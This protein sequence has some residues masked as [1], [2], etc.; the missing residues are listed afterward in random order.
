MVWPGLLGRGTALKKHQHFWN[1]EES[2]SKVFYFSYK[3]IILT[4]CST[5]IWIK[6][7]FVGDCKR[8]I[9]EAGYKIRVATEQRRLP[10]KKQ[11]PDKTINT[12]NI[13]VETR[14][15]PF[16]A[17][18]TERKWAKAGWGLRNR[19]TGEH[20]AIGCCLALAREQCSVLASAITTPLRPRSPK[21]PWES[22][23]TVCRGEKPE[24]DC[25]YSFKSGDRLLGCRGLLKHHLTYPSSYFPR[26]TSAAKWEAYGWGWSHW[27]NV[28]QG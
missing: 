11:K 15:E 3:P 26:S 27:V 18:Q 7:D 17:L 14:K 22:K 9:R 4:L 28:A 2:Y 5:V 21:E 24:H 8:I 25:T 10:F 1:W 6:K 13:R 23:S 12:R 16:C 20:T 19:K